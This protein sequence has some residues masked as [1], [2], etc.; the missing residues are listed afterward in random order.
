MALGSDGPKINTC[1][2]PAPDVL[3]D[4]LEAAHIQPAFEQ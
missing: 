1:K 2:E 4:M 3:L